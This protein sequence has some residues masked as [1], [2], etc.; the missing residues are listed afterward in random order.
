MALFTSLAL[1][2]RSISLLLLPFVTRAMSAEE[3]GIVSILTAAGALL[4]TL[5]G[6]AVEQG[7][8]RATVRSDQ[9]QDTSQRNVLSAAWWWLAA[10]GPAI[11]FLAAGLLLLYGESILQVPA[12]LWAIEIAAAGLNLLPFGFAM[13]TLRARQ[14]L[15][16][17]AVVAATSILVGLISKIVLVVAL[18]GGAL[19]WVITDLITAGATLIASLF[20]VHPPRYG[21]AR[22]GA[23]SLAR[24][25]GPLIPHT[26]SFWAFSSLS[27]PLMA[28]VMPLADVGTYSVALNAASVGLLVLNEINRAATVSYAADQA[29]ALSPRTLGLMRVQ[30]WSG[31]G[32]T[33]LTCSL[34]PAFATYIIPSTYEGVVQILA[35]LSLQP[36]LWSVYVL[37]I[38]VLTQTV[39]NTTWNWTASVSATLVMAAGTIV[40]GSVSGATG[41]AVA[42]VLGYGVMALAAHILIRLESV[43]IQWRAAGLGWPFALGGGTIAVSVVAITYLD[44][45]VLLRS[46]VV[47]AAW[48][49][50]G[51]VGYAIR[52]SRRNAP[53]D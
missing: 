49:A 28:L 33:V 51:F 26:L 46:V 14:R 40:L 9:N 50:L 18:G 23:A 44:S 16:R 31:V 11:C 53:G 10:L 27:R 30:L 8:F 29:P 22:S 41:A 25:A 1:A 36:L 24:Y 5:L 37:P 4:P 20:L 32:V 19:G 6:S 47:G 42:G 7:V 2:Q 15:A 34:A 38:N 13:P 21:R 48:I 17:F 45:S 3:Y 52:S 43:R 39:G 12:S 35:I